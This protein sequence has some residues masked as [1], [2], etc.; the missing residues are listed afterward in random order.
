MKLWTFYHINKDMLNKN[1]VYETG[2]DLKAFTNNKKYALMFIDTRDIK[3]FIVRKHNITKEEYVEFVNEHPGKKLDLY[4][5]SIRDIG[6]HTDDG[7]IQIDMLMTYDEHVYIDEPAFA[8][9]DTSFWDSVPFPYIFKDKYFKALDAFEYVK[10]FKVYKDMFNMKPV[11]TQ[12]LN[13][14][15][16]DYAAPEFKLDPFTLLLDISNDTF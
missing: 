5:V 15:E 3:K 11:Y 16:D 2:Y 1:G 13:A 8:I 14:D 4:N 6:K 9:D 12:F 7:T 10:M